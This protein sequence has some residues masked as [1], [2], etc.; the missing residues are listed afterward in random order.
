MVAIL[1]KL[2]YRFNA[3]P[4]KIQ[5][6]FKKEINKLILKCI[7]AYKGLNW[8]KQF[9][10]RTKLEDLYYSISKFTVKLQ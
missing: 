9:G 1:S 4:N 2:I 3:I 8:S 5:L 10:K 7:Q 6:D